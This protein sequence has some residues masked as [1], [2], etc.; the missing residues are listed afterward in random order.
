M[1]K[2][3]VK[4]SNYYFNLPMEVKIS[5]L[6]KTSNVLGAEIM[7]FTEKGNLVAYCNLRLKDF[8]KISHYIEEI[9]V[10]N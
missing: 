10:K 4:F 1:I 6:E 2:V 5:C 8:K 3:L 9:I 7:Y